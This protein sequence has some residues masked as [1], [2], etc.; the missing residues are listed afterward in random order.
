M[1]LYKLHTIV[2]KNVSGKNRD[3]YNFQQPKQIRESLM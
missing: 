3:K 1:K 2:Q